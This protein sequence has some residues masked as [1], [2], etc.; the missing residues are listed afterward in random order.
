[1]P[2]GT[3]D[4]V[5]TVIVMS[6]PNNAYAEWAQ[7][8]LGLTESQKNALLS[9]GI[10]TGFMITTEDPRPL[11]VRFAPEKK[12]LVRD[13]IADRMRALRRSVS[14][15]REEVRAVAQ[16][17]ETEVAEKPKPQA[18]P[19]TLEEARPKV[20]EMEQ[21][22]HMAKPVVREEARKV[23]VRKPRP[24]ATEFRE[25]LEYWTRPGSVRV[26]GKPEVDERRCVTCGV[27]MPPGSDEC[28]ICAPRLKTPAV[29]VVRKV[30]SQPEPV[31]VSKPVSVPR[32]EP[33]VKSVSEP[34]EDVV[35]VRKAE[36]PVEPSPRPKPAVPE[37][38][39][40]KPEV[41]VDSAPKSEPPAPRPAPKPVAVPVTGTEKAVPRADQAPKTPAQTSQ[42]RVRTVSLT[43]MVVVKPKPLPGVKPRSGGESR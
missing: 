13:A 20:K 41:P 14:V 11:F 17:T 10:G 12:A 7:T 21:S 28:P 34:R 38:A 3:I 15:Q 6:H 39:V 2:P 5:G 43:G 9:G 16:R 33:V 1:M 35:A 23:S 25:D 8:Y 42:P 29:R 37:P 32:P 27:P 18:K 19:V 22:Q 26:A 24:E 30:A 36:P 31:T 4:L 40:Q